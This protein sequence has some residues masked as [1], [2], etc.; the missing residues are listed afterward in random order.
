MEVPRRSLLVL[1]FRIEKED[2]VMPVR[3]LSPLLENS[4]DLSLDLEPRLPPSHQDAVVTP[5]GSQFLV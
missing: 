1:S 2:H 4:L 5:K 3:Q